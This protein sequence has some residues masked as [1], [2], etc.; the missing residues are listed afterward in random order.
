MTKVFIWPSPG[1]LYFAMNKYLEDWK[2][3]N[4]QID[5]A[6]NGQLQESLAAWRSLLNLYVRLT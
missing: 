6:P 2:M 1:G 5:L 3:K 4:Y